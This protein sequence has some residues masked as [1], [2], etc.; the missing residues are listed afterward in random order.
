MCQKGTSP[1]L[2]SRLFFFSSK[3]RHQ[4][5]Y[6][7][8][9]WNTWAATWCVFF[10]AQSIECDFM[11]KWFKMKANTP[12]PWEQNLIFLQYPWS[13]NESSRR[14]I[15]ITGR[16]FSSV[17]YRSVDLPHKY[18]Q[19]PRKKNKKYQMPTRLIT[20]VKPEKKQKSVWTWM[21]MN[22]VIIV[23]HNYTYIIHICTVCLHKG[24]QESYKVKHHTMLY[25]LKKKHDWLEPLSRT[26][27]LVP[28]LAH[29][30]W[31]ASEVTE[32]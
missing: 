4:W 31:G 13:P 7:S 12:Q 16:S 30:I 1:S 29:L 26:V 5:L 21:Q 15:G 18:P 28:I 32:A 9:W 20:V 17:W 22:I 11:I 25:Q 6:V 3:Q 23:N 14:F 10:P 2:A 27:R 8:P 19:N 24:I